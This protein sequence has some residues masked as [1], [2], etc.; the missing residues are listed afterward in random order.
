MN[1]E[2]KMIEITVDPKVA[3]ALKKAF[4]SPPNSSV[5]ALSKYVT[6]LKFMLINALLRG[7]TPE[8]LKLNLFSI[9]LHDLANK[10]GQIGRGK[11]VRVHAWLRDNG[12]A[13]V[14]YAVLGTNLSGV[15]SKVK[16]TDLVTLDMPQLVQPANTTVIDDV[17]IANELLAATAQANADLINH[18][19]PDFDQCVAAQTLDQVF[20]AVDVDIASLENYIKWLL[21]DSKLISASKRKHYL[22]QAQ[23]ILSVAKDKGGKYYQRKKPSDFG[24]T[25]YAGTSVQNVNKELR[26]AILGN[27]WEYDIRSSVVAWKMGYATEFLAEK[28]LAANVRSIFPCTLSYLENK[29][30]FMNAV[31]HVVF[32]STSNLA[33]ALQVKILKQAFTALS[34]GARK[35]AKGWMDSN[36]GWV[37]PAIVDIIQVKDERERFLA[38]KSVGGFIAEQNMLDTFLFD[39]FKQM[40]PDLLKLPY[41]QTQGGNPSKAKVIAFMYQHEETTVMDIVRSAVVEHGK[42]VLANIHDA[43]IVKQ[44]LGAEL[45]QEIELRMQEQTVNPY[46]RLGATELQRYE[47]SSKEAKLEELAHKQRMQQLEATAVGY[48]SPFIS[49]SSP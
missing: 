10:G 6:Q 2:R 4:P 41:L 27:C 36:G 24:R 15:V 18:L 20:D 29:T 3:A 22:F 32:G 38:D 8:E 25:Y 7:Q 33:E 44:R 31:Q 11:K 40:R 47:S 35:T 46:W 9:S 39:T 14:E 13:L 23:I 26:R 37:K 49:S 43:I 42:T 16:L 48:K 17:T 30:V 28:N 34:F 19:Y 21:E 45:K 1:F 5:R 12:F